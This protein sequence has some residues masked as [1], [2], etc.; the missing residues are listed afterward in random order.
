M[1]APEEG[2]RLFSPTIARVRAFSAA[3]YRIGIRRCLKSIVFSAILG[4]YT[5]YTQKGFRR[6]GKFRVLLITHSLDPLK[7]VKRHIR[8]L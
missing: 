4:L 2:L 8:Y 6:T 7:Q 5:P 3:S 1:S